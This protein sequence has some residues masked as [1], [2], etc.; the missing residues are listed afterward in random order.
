MK[1]KK[2]PPKS[3]TKTFVVDGKLYVANDMP[4]SDEIRERMDGL[5]YDVVTRV[6][7]RQDYLLRCRACEGPLVRTHFV[8][9]TA[10]PECPHCIAQRRETAAAKI[11]VEI[12]GTDPRKK[13]YGFFKLPCGHVVRRQFDRVQKA[14]SGGFELGCA[15]CREKTYAAAARKHDWELLG[16]TQPQKNNYR[17]YRHSCGYA[18][19]VA[20][21]NMGWGQVECAN[22]GGGYSAKQSFIYLFEINLPGLPVLKLGYSARPAK[23]LRHQLEIPK[24]VATE[25]LRVIPMA[26]GQTARLEEEAAHRW[27]TAEYPHFYVP[28]EIY[29]D[30]INTKRE[31]YKRDAMPVIDRMLDDIAARHSGTESGE[32]L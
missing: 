21:A 10:K 25:I 8:V 5:G 3:A 31:I 14:A 24:D 7:D 16:P 1:N 32:T 28:K 18:Q 2:T 23:R 20:I 12:L 29:G 15:E 22:C 13:L 19:D 30:Q 11:G 27:L 17:Q 9:R 4:V 6:G 26:K